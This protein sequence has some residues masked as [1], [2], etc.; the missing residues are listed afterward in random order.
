[1]ASARCYKSG[2]W[3]EPLRATVLNGIRAYCLKVQGYYK[4][5]QSRPAC[6]SQA[7]ANTNWVFNFSN[8]GK[9]GM[10]LDYHYCEDSI[11]KQ[12]N[13]CDRGGDD[14]ENWWFFR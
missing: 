2:D 12:I 7:N 6:V 9:N 14:T 1:M 10:T 4:G 13:G 5:G 11:R 8:T 3:A